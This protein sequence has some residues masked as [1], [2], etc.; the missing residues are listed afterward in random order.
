MVVLRGV[1]RFVLHCALPRFTVCVSCLV[2]ERLLSTPSDPVC[3]VLQGWLHQKMGVAILVSSSFSLL[4]VQEANFWLV[5]WRNIFC[6][7]ADTMRSFCSCLRTSD[8]HCGLERSEYGTLCDCLGTCA[9][10]LFLQFS[11]SLTC[12]DFFFFFILSL[13]KEEEKRSMSVSRVTCSYCHCISPLKKKAVIFNQ[14]VINYWSCAGWR[15]TCPVL[16]ARW[17]I[18]S[19]DVIIQQHISG[20]FSPWDGRTNQ[21]LR[22]KPLYS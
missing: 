6:S 16:F 3:W 14:W 18:C 8:G 7:S 13:Q 15:D 20:C 2:H 1:W 10:A 21:S 4:F 17:I 11:W 9:L 12:I 22:T 5:L 19:Q